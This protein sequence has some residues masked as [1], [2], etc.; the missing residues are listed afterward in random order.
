MIGNPR[1][2]DPAPAGRGIRSYLRWRWRAVLTAL[3]LAGLLLS[4]CAGAAREIGGSVPAGA[5]LV[6]DAAGLPPA[7]RP[8]HP[9]PDFTLQDMDG[10]N[11]KLSDLKGKPVLINFW[12]TW[13]PPCRAEMPDIETVYQRHKA[14]GL[15][16]LGVDVQEDKDAVSKYVQRGGFSWTFLLDTS[17][18]VFFNRYRGAAFPSSFFVDK[19]GVVQDVSIGALNEKGLENKLAKILSAAAQ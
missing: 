12:T 11:V 15:V 18:E 14:E 5:G 19:E 2:S 3:A 4:A 10:K 1:G 13:C 8:G 6:A 7:P 17:G 16:V 9:A